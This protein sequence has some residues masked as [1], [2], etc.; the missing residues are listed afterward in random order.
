MFML[1]PPG[2]VGDY[3][4]EAQDVPGG[5]PSESVILRRHVTLLPIIKNN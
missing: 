5:N 4:L 1:K 3:K 2:G